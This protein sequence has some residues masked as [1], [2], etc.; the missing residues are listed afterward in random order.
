MFL[1]ITTPE[2]KLYSGEVT[3]VHLPGTLGRFQILKNHA[4]MISTLGKGVLK[5]KDEKGM[6]TFDISGGVVEVLKNK[7]IILAEKN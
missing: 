6:E 4:P 3:T 2:K 5:V 7:I 1:E